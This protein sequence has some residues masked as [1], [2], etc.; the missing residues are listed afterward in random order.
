MLLAIWLAPLQAFVYF[1][2]TLC[3]FSAFYRLD[4]LIEFERATST[5]S[6]LAN[7][8]ISHT[9]TDRSCTHN[10]HADHYSAHTHIGRRSWLW[11]RSS[12]PPLAA[13]VEAVEFLIGLVS[14]VCKTSRA[15]LY[16]LADVAL[17]FSSF[18][19]W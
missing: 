18:K 3:G 17:C 9:R 8:G 6:P 2:P 7:P 16:R 15:M 19:V 4:T 13:A 1:T 10:S 11:S 5:K 14:E 12:V